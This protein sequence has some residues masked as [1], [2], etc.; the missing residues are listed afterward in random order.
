M[1]L[2]SGVHLFHSLCSQVHV[3]SIQHRGTSHP[4]TLPRSVISWCRCRGGSIPRSC[5]PW[6]RASRPRISTDDYAQSSNRAHGSRCVQLY[7]LHM[8]AAFT[9][10]LR[11]DSA[12]LNCSATSSMH[13]YVHFRMFADPPVACRQGCL[14]AQRAWNPAFFIQQRPQ[15]V[16]G[17]DCVPPR[18]GQ[19][20]GGGG[21]HSLP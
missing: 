6:A 8:L 1:L 10:Q 15:P 7:L 3:I 13:T 4:S 19:R 18:P 17:Q 12:A 14:Q 21:P 5:I 11:L 2:L 9:L 16:P 20:W